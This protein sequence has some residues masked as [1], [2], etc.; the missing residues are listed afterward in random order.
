MQMKIQILNLVIPERKVQAFSSEFISNHILST[1]E[2][3]RKAMNLGLT[4]AWRTY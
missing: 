4:E 3:I 1:L 2:L